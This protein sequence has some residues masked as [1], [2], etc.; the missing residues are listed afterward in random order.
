MILNLDKDLLR[1]PQCGSVW[2]TI[3]KQYCLKEDKNKS[4]KYDTVF[5]CT[6]IKTVFKCTECGYITYQPEEHK[7]LKLNIPD[8][9]L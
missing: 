3:E 4:A 2:H 8:N 7:S 9:Y 5:D 1:C 6:K